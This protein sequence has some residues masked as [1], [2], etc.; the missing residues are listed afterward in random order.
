MEAPVA[1]ILAGGASSRM[2]RDKALL[3]LADG[4]VACAAVVEAARAAA[5]RVVLLVDTEQHADRLL[6]MLTPPLP[7]VLLDRDPGSGPLA[8]LAGALAA[9]EE[10]ALV[11]LAVDMPL[12]RPAVLRALYARWREVTHGSL[13]PADGGPIGGIVAPVI[14]GLTQPMPAC[15]DTRLA[16]AATRLL[17]AGRR[18]LRAL[19]GASE[20]R[21]F[22]LSEA[23]LAA[24]DPDLG[25]FAGANTPEE[26]RAISDLHVRLDQKVG[27]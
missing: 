22:P 8:S 25:S 7:E 15:Y 16:G 21:V 1:A 10:Q 2:G 3:T 17:G 14:G 6:G 13:D 4:R 9:A 20:A 19:L 12:V 18:D 5:S 24:L 26:W 11:L 23:E 27:K